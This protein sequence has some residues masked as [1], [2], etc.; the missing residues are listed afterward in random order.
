PHSTT[1]AARTDGEHVI[2]HGDPG[3]D[4]GP[5]NNVP[6]DR[7]WHNAK[8]HLGFKVVRNDDGSLTWTTPLG[9]TFT[10][11]PYDYRLGP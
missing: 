11:H 1:P 4:T 3:G 6:M 5:D 2:R 8:T 9:Q 7:G 10:V